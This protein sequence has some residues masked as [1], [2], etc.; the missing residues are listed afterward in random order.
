MAGRAC[1]ILSNV[2]FV[3]RWCKTAAL[4]TLLH[5][6]PFQASR[7]EISSS[8]DSGFAATL[9]AVEATPAA[10]AAAPADSAGAP[11]AAAPMPLTVSA[12]ESPGS[13]CAA[14]KACSL[15]AVCSTDTNMHIAHY[16][17]LLRAHR[18]TGSAAHISTNTKLATPSPAAGSRAA[19]H[20]H[21][22][23]TLAPNSCSWLASHCPAGRRLCRARGRNEKGLAWCKAIKLTSWQAF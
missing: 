1:S 20:A 2:E 13:C 11:E 3:V 21:V 10:A 6:T 22:S 7:S 5:V 15:H 23:C 18:A 12:A 16:C 19:V 17:S 9:S 4:V 14:G 8:S